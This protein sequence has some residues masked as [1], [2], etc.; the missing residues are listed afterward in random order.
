MDQ[1]DIAP[2]ARRL[3]EENNVNWRRLRGSGD[4]GRVVERDVLEYLARVMAGEEATDPT[5]EPVPAGMEAW[6][7][8]E[9]RRF[10]QGDDVDD[11]AEPT[12]TVEDDIFLFDE[13]ASGGGPQDEAPASAP[14][15]GDGAASETLHDAEIVED[16]IDEDDLL[17]AG[18]D[19]PVP[20]EHEPH[21]AR[22]HL[23]QPVAMPDM[24]AATPA[25][26]L[27]APEDEADL[28]S[29]FG[30]SD[31]GQQASVETPP[32]V[33]GEPLGGADEWSEP[34][35]RSEPHAD[36]ALDDPADEPADE[37]A[38]EPAGEPDDEPADEPVTAEAVP[39]ARLDVDVQGLDGDA[40][41]SDD[42]AAGGDEPTPAVGEWAGDVEFDGPEQ[43]PSLD[44]V[45][46]D[47]AQEQAERHFEYGALEP[48]AAPAEATEQQAGEYE[49][50]EQQAGEYE[51]GAAGPEDEAALPPIAVPRAETPRPTTSGE[52]PLLSHGHVWRRQ[53]DLSALVSAQ[54]DLAAD[55]G[56]DAPVPLGAFLIRAAHKAIGGGGGVAL[57][58][59]EDGSVRTVP[60]S[61]T[62]DFAATVTSLGAALANGRESEDSSSAAQIVVADLSELGLDDAVLRLG[63]P[64]LTLGRVL[65]D[66]QSGGR[67]A[68]LSLAGDG[69][70]GTDAA[71]LLVRVAELLEAPV[72]VVL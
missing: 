30:A 13:L 5:P 36:E 2:L 35:W 4:A 22:E 21:T 43:L 19:E 69:V 38:G 16:D 59:L 33:F 29:L 51:A 24:W 46:G 54:A 61:A 70:D 37:P 42:D 64:V 15:A 40:F 67:R 49:A 50:T 52:L 20:T 66:N 28:P 47:A 68:M 62:G 1:P 44:A 17:V 27:T 7:D 63:A 31:A 72:R 56:R 34:V 25:D 12:S 23:Q 45:A 14:V 41:T 57:A 55:L 10:G 8:D 58:L 48:D 3:A 26:D 11:P 60:V 53:V 6:P 32:P 18:D 9:V 71:R 39:T 65:I